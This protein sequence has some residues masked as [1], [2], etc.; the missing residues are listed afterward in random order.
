[1]HTGRVAGAQDGDGGAGGEDQGLGSG[2]PGARR[3]IA[4]GAP[5]QEAVAE[6]QQSGPRVFGQD[7][8]RAVGQIAE[9]SLEADLAAGARLDAGAM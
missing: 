3:R 8:E 9:G 2:G 7:D 4:G 1:M 6:D 5:G